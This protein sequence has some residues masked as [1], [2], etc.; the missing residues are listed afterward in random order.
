M[1]INVDGVLTPQDLAAID[2]LSADAAK[3]AYGLVNAKE[4]EI[5]DLIR[6]IE[7]NP[8]KALRN[9]KVQ[10]L[11]KKMGLKFPFGDP[12]GLSTKAALKKLSANLKHTSRQLRQVLAKLKQVMEGKSSEISQAATEKY[13]A[14]TGAEIEKILRD[15]NMSIEEKFMM[16]A[17]TLAAKMENE[18]EQKMEE[19]AKL[20]SGSGDKKSGGGIGDFF[21][22]LFKKIGKTFLNMLFPGLGEMVD[23]AVSAASGSGKEMDKDEKNMKSKQLETQIQLLM[24]RM[25]RMTTM[26][27]TLLADD[28]K[29]KSSVIGNTR[30]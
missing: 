15:P 25:N 2:N 3:A 14:D 1:S 16:L 7:T 19:W 9:S 13:G 11:L 27:S 12:L 10:Q 24:Q 18:I 17:T 4:N 21:K 20:S 30:V 29:T 22:N 26:I 28:H 23:K 8:R 6:L 5:L